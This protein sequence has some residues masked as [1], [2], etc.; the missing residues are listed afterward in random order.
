M[1]LRDKNNLRQTK[2]N[3]LLI[4]LDTYYKLKKK[5]LTIP[6]FLITI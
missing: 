4:V 5:T 6:L 1:V 2:S 3:N